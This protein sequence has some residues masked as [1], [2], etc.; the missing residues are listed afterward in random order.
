MNIME[1][2]SKNRQRY[3]DHLYQLTLQNELQI[4]SNTGKR[5]SRGEAAQA[6]SA[7][8]RTRPVRTPK[9]NRFKRI[10][11]QFVEF[12]EEDESDEFE[13]SVANQSNP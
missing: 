8:V 13:Y 5:E 1:E 10:R 11:E 2:I 3:Y 6:H 4:E 12:F 9:P 7:K